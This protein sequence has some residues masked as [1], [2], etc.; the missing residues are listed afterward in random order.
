MEGEGYGATLG[1]PRARIAIVRGDLA[2]LEEVLRDKD[3]ESRLSWFSL[4]AVAVRLDA[5]AVLGDVES[6]VRKRPASGDPELHQP[7][8]LRA[9]AIVPRMT[10]CSA[11]APAIQC[12]AARLVHSADPE[13]DRATQSRALS[14]R[15][16]HPFPIRRSEMSDVAKV[17]T[18]IG[19]SPESFAKAADIAVQNA[20]KTIRGIPART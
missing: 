17:I 16:R 18:L 6:V 12:P 5:D 1:T 3:W 7:F 9:R 14:P 15:L 20:A 8:T 11:G 2:A 13:P 4:P 10:R 19:Q